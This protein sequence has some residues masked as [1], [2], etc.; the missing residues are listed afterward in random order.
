MLDSATMLHPRLTLSFLLLI[1]LSASA[2]PVHAEFPQVMVAPA[3]TPTAEPVPQTGHLIVLAS[4]KTADE[5]NALVNALPTL[6][7]LPLVPGYPRAIDT[8]TMSGLRPGYH[9]VI[10]GVCAAKAQARLIKDV[11]QLATGLAATVRE[12]KTTNVDLGCPSLIPQKASTLPLV[13]RVPL[14]E[15][16]PDINWVVRKKDL[17]DQCSHYALGVEVGKTVVYQTTHKETGCGKNSIN[18]TRFNLAIAKVGKVSYARLGQRNDWHDNGNFN[19]SLLGLSCT[20]V[21]DLLTLGDQYDTVEEITASGDG[22]GRTQVRL[23]W[24]RGECSNCPPSGPAEY[25]RSTDGC[26]FELAK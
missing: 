26:S 8:A 6:D 22:T 20:G 24:K 12:V 4:F 19:E 1:G 21:H 13:E 9:A 14:D 25:K 16:F 15:R 11:L 17:N 3:P 2:T 18:T 10:A 23:L 7:F 5:A